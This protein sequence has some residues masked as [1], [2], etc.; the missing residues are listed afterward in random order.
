MRLCVLYTLPDIEEALAVAQNPAIDAALVRWHTDAIV[1][2]GL[3]CNSHR[4]QDR[5]H[6]Q[7]RC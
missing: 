5:C 7:V 3:L 4:L 2:F 1:A 6:R